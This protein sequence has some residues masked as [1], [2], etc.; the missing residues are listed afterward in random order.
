MKQSCAFQEH[1]GGRDQNLEFQGFILVYRGL[2]LLCI[3]LVFLTS[4][5]A[6]AHFH[7]KDSGDTDRSCSL[8]ALA[9]AGVAVSSV[10]SP[11]PVFTP[12]AVTELPS[13]SPRSLLLVSSYYIRPP[14]LG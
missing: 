6:A 5:I 7:P 14:P 4:F 11:A 2:T 12:T 10:A 3:L 13:A 8:C 1:A 9:H